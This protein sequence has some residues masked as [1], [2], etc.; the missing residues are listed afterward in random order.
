MIQGA[1]FG[2]FDKHKQRATL[3]VGE[4]PPV[5]N[6]TLFFAVHKTFKYGLVSTLYHL[7]LHTNGI[8]E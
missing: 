1:D 8:V 7:M 5:M 3:G 4:Y 2:R 6:C